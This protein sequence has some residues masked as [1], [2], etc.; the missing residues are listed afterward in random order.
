MSDVDNA[1]A[2]EAWNTVLFDKFCRF[3]YVLT[4]GLSGHS[5]ELLRRRPFPAGAR[6]LDVGCGF[7]DTTQRIAAHV[8]PGG[9]AVGVDCA[10]GFIDIAAR[11]ARE[12]S[13]RNASFLVADAQSDDLGGPYDYVFSRF[14]TMFF[15]LPGRAMRNI[16]RALAPGGELAMIVW[17]KREDNLWLY[18]AEQRVKQIVPV[19]SHDETDQVH[20]GPGPFS[21]A[22]ADM[23]SDLLRDAGYGRITFARFDTDVCIGRSLDDAVAFA[24]ELGPAGEII[25]LAGDAGERCRALV[26]AALRETLSA[27]ERN[28]GIWAPSSTW[29]VTA[30][31]GA[32]SR[33]RD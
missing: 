5:D 15:N 17:R 25:R 29:F 4:E 12:A 31:K 18:E 23:V 10:R 21:M 11:E 22:S 32:V 19:V 3:R 28:D 8:T 24:L 2:I 20:C 13:I 7:G 6:V 9:E 27:Y 33:A 1:I 26:I 30:C 16:H 14:G